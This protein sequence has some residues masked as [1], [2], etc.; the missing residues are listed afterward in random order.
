MVGEVLSK[1]GGEVDVKECRRLSVT[2]SFVVVVDAC[3]S[4]LGDR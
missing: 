3:A 4:A 1:D 2:D